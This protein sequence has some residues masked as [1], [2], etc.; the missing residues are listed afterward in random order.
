M[1]K[2]ILMLSR[3][4]S[5]QPTLLRLESARLLPVAVL[6]RVRRRADL[7]PGVSLRVPFLGA[8]LPFVSGPLPVC[9]PEPVRPARH[10]PLRPENLAGRRGAPRLARFPGESSRC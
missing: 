8:G 10:L 9:L 5:C 7:P 3:I 2:G 6:L 1:V 4:Q